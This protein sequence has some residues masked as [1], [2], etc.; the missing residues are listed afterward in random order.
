[1]AA[2]FTVRVPAFSRGGARARGHLVTANSAPPASAAPTAARKAADKVKLGDSD[3]N[4]SSKL[5]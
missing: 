5:I 2:L 4:V 1:M 3:L